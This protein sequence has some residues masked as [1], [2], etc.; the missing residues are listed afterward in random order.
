MSGRWKVFLLP[1]AH[2]QDIR[3]WFGKLLSG[4]QKLSIKRGMLYQP[5]YCPITGPI[6]NQH[7]A[8]LF[9][10]HFFEDLFNIFLTQRRVCGSKD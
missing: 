8:F 2:I 4:D 3:V 10:R 5:H 6:L 9:E 1:A 7:E